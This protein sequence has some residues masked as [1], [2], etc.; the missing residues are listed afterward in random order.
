MVKEKQ[1][2]YHNTYVKS[3]I[4]GTCICILSPIPLFIGAFTE[5]DFLCV[6]MLTITMLIAGIGVTFFVISGIRWASMQ[7]LLKE[8][9]FA[10]E[11][12]KKNKVKEVI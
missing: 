10:L 1:K 5:N 9:E 6:I 12:K 7:K 4:I 2:A 11:E 8:G 3:N